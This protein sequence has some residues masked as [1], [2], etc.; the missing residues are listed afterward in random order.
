[1]KTTSF[2]F[3]F[4]GKVK[5]LK[6]AIRKEMLLQCEPKKELPFDNSPVSNI[7]ETNEIFE[8]C[9]LFKNTI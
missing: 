5:D 3:T 7:F 9:N 1:M 4:K 8:Q 6:K 2:S